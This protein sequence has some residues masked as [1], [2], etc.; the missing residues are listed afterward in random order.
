MKVKLNPSIQK[1]L[2]SISQ[3]LK[4]RPYYTSP[5]LVELT[6]TNSTLLVTIS[7]LRKYDTDSNEKHIS[8]VA[9]YYE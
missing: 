1:T 6:N 7:L 4:L 5:Y 8:T 2:D 9:Y 3:T